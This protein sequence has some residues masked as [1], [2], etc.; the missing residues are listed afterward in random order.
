MSKAPLSD[1]FD[2]VS[3][4]LGDPEVK[5]KI[6]ISAVYI[7]NLFLLTSDAVAHVVNDVDISSQQLGK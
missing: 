2:S 5:Q 3:G 4:T 6:L 1:R 7:A